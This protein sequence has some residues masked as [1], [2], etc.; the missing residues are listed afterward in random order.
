[1]GLFAALSNQQQAELA[2]ESQ[3]AYAQSKPIVYKFSSSMCRDCIELE[4]TMVKIRPNYADKINFINYSV[5]RRDRKIKELIR[6]YQLTVVPTLVF[7]DSKG[8]VKLKIEGR[9][10]QD[11]LE[12]YLKA[13]SNDG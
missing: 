10:S 1:M 11:K 7:V 6:K 12:N 13:L 9:I 3:A 5:D 2:S 4:K 8:N